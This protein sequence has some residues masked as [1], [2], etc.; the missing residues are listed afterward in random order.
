MLFILYSLYVFLDSVHVYS[1]CHF[2]C[3]TFGILKNKKI[4]KFVQLNLHVVCM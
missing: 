4:I 2:D 3:A 1:L